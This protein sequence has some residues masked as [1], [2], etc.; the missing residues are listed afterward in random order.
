MLGLK[1]EASISNIT[2]MR[3]STILLTLASLL[4][5]TGCRVD[6]TAEPK[7]TIGSDYQVMVICDDDIWNG[8]LAMAVCDLLE[9]DIPGLV[10]PEGYFNI[11]KQVDPQSA[12]DMDKR[13]GIV[14]KVELSAASTEPKYSVVSNIYAR[15]QIILTLTAADAEQAV[16]Y[17]YSH[18]DE[19]REVMNESER[20]EAIKAASGK[21]AKQ[22]MDDFAKNTGHTML[23]PYSFSKANPAD[24]ELTWYIRDYANKAQYIFAFTTDYDPEVSIEDESATIANAI[25]HKFNTISSKGADGSYMQISPYREV[26]A[27][28]LDING[29]PMLELRGCWEVENDYMGGSFTAYTIFDSETSRATVVIFAIYA[30]EDTQRNLMR[31]LECLIYTLE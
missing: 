4:I 11:A 21:P 20:N 29:T 2:A 22:L 23:I 1:F 28:V 3:H 9:S 7:T 6:S 27:D 19:L 10:R 14:F 31:E 12:T 17:I 16:S 5:F 30:P 13:Y 8:D 25:N 15:P 18:A 24:E 26:V